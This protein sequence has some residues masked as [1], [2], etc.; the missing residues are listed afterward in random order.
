M[1]T[2]TTTAG[3]TWDMIAY[4]FYG[5][6]YNMTELQNANTQ[7]LGVVVFDAGVVIN[8]PEIEIPEAGGLP[9]WKR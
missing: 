7:Y 8:I 6:E 5:N 1:R 4:R 3:D 9:P 2:Y